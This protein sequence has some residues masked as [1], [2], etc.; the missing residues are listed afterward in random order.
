MNLEPQ[1]S[2][3]DDFDDAKK[4]L[5]D[6]SQEED[7]VPRKDDFNQSIAMSSNVNSKNSDQI[8]PDK[9]L[10]VLSEPMYEQ[11]EP[12]F[13]IDEEDLQEP[14]TEFENKAVFEKQYEML[15]EVSEIALKSFYQNEINIPFSPSSLEILNP[16]KVLLCILVTI[17]NILNNLY[18]PVLPPRESQ[19]DI[20]DDDEFKA[21][22]K[23][24][25]N[26]CIKFV[27][28]LVEAVKEG[29][30]GVHSPKKKFLTKMQDL[31]EEMICNELFC[32]TTPSRDRPAHSFDPLITAKTDD[33]HSVTKL[34]EY[35]INKALKTAKRALKQYF[36]NVKT[37]KV[38]A[39]E[40][41]KTGDRGKIPF[42]DFTTMLSDE[43]I[44]YLGSNKKG[45]KRNKEVKDEILKEIE[46]IQTIRH[47]MKPKKNPNPNSTYFHMH[48]LI[49]I[50]GNNKNGQALLIEKIPEEIVLNA[51][52]SV[53]NRYLDG[54]SDEHLTIAIENIFIDQQPP[55]EAQRKQG[56]QN[57]GKRKE[58]EL[59]VMHLSEALPTK[60]S[61]YSEA[62]QK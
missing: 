22:Q 26:D 36:K 17:L 60:I 32:E 1:Y 33:C 47:E 56:N 50:E 16:E 55:N 23:K 61:I 3:I 30:P 35:S 11:L 7:L 44:K 5:I 4:S 58:E 14:N 59:N 38:P 39:L 42:V 51:V 28:E 25:K 53:M 49:R 34:F 46:L 29:I 41:L 10:D 15:D 52:C 62:F 18:Q 45:N 2:E 37:S 24:N 6:N 31:L 43:F 19:I 21:R 54:I 20:K 48:C 13:Q 12:I 27:R 8:H 40:Y 57:L 9:L